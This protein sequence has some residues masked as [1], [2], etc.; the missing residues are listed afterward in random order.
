YLINLARADLPDTYL[1]QQASQSADN[2]DESDLAQWDID[3][4]YHTPRPLDTPAEARWTENLVQVI[5][6]RRFRM[7][8]EEVYE[9]AKRHSSGGALDLCA[10]LKEGL[11]VLLRQ[12]AMLDEYVDGMEDCERHYVMAQCLLQWRARRIYRY[13]NEV[14]AMMTGSNPYALDSSI[15]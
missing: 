2:L 6:G 10:E 11:D 1:F 13:H 7:E 3:P 4:P 9:R 5:H 14:H 8:K 15:I 12:W